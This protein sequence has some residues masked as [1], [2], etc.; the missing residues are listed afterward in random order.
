M[1][2]LLGTG[3]IYTG[4]NV[5]AAAVPF[6][7]LPI[8]TRALEP[9]QYGQVVLFFMLITMCSSVSGLSV[10]SAVAVRWLD[11]ERGDPRRY[12]GSALVVAI[13][14]MGATAV[15][16]GIVAASFDIGLTVSLSALAAVVAGT[17]IIQG[18][19]FAIWQCSQ[20]PWPAA[21][22][23]VS[24]A[25]LN[26][27]LSLFA[28]FALHQGAE[29]R[30][31]GA[32]VASICIATLSIIL[33]VK[34]GSAGKPNKEDMRGLLR[35]GL[36][37]V[38][39]ALASALLSSADRFAVSTTHGAAALGIY[40]SAYQI[41]AVINVLGDSVIKTYSPT[42]YRMLSRRSIRQD[43]RVVAITYLSIPFWL[44]SAVLLWVAFKVAAPVLLGE[45]YQNATDLALWFLLGGACTA[46][47]LN[48]AGLFFFTGKTEWLSA[49]TVASAAFAWLTAFPVVA[50]F[51]V[52]GGAMVY[53]AAQAALL[54][55]AWGLSRVVRPMPWAHPA[56][57][58]RVL[59]RRF[60][61]KPA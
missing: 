50:I 8:L 39:H 7:L 25:V 61:R 23:Q 15:V 51:G 60:E 55:A 31:L 35:F 3:A 32:A 56:L 53:L 33:L 12:T 5:L 36:P 13:L 21:T 59:L 30:I 52:E 14:S 18:T 28:V 24:G 22:L 10:H 20:R 49:A 58:M 1:R 57:A 6:L 34:D 37:L 46:V 26:I 9:E 43:L 17:A 44:C 4:A 2:S 19:R 45:S 38:P 29:G 40:G 54:A 48:I 42:M 27:S 11:T 41:G 47:Y 16:M